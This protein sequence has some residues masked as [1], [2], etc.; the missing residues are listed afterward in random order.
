MANCTYVTVR[1]IFSLPGGERQVL[2]RWHTDQ[3]GNY[4]TSA[5]EAHCCECTEGYVERVTVIHQ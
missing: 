2:A 4:A 1:N 3:Q 5:P